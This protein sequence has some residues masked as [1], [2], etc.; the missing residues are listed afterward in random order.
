LAIISAQTLYAQEWKKKTNTSYLNQLSADLNKIY[1]DYR[2]AVETYAFE[3][4][5]LIRQVTDNGRTV[6]LVRIMPSGLPEFY[7]THNLKAAENVGTTRLRP[8]ADLSLNLT[9][10]NILVGVWDSGSTNVEHQEFWRP[11]GD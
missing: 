5:I 9:G 6:S 3:R 1:E 4:D 8:R 2:S 7:M 10:K 11:R